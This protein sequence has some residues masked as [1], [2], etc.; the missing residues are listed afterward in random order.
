MNCPINEIFDKPDV[1]PRN[2]IIAPVRVL[3]P[4]QERPYDLI[5]WWDMEEF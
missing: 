5:S 1:L 3:Q 4:W 2:G